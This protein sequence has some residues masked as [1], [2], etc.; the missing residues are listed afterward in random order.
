[1]I[2]YHASL[3]PL[4]HTFEDALPHAQSLASNG[5]LIVQHL[6]QFLAEISMPLDIE[7]THQQLMMGKCRP[8]DHVGGIRERFDEMKHALNR[9]GVTWAD[10]L[11]QK[12]HRCCECILR[13]ADSIDSI[14]EDSHSC[15][16]DQWCDC[17][18][19]SDVNL[20]SRLFRCVMLYYDQLGNEEMKSVYKQVLKRSFRVPPGHAPQPDPSHHASI[21]LS[22]LFEPPQ[23]TDPDLMA[24]RELHRH[25]ERRAV[26]R[27]G[28][29]RRQRYR[30]L[31]DRNSG[32]VL[33]VL[34]RPSKRSRPV[35]DTDGKPEFPKQS[36][37]SPPP[38][39]FSPALLIEPPGDFPMP[40]L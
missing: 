31:I 9:W 2:R 34:H 8:L 26:R 18:C 27:G 23:S 21:D 11:A 14:N 25:I 24:R 12:P 39:L 20:V 38:A 17:I 40:D 30:K 3:V 6:G 35:G 4:C 1:M 29:R 32:R 15:Q 13:S 16:C 36:T 33:A 19:H 7:S 10:S 37:R 22:P 28:D 5:V